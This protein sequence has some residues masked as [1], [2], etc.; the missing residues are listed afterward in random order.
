MVSLWLL[1]VTPPV[2]DSVLLK[3]F[4]FAMNADSGMA[5]VSEF[6]HK[7][8]RENLHEC[9]LTLSQLHGSVASL[10]EDKRLSR[11]R[12]HVGYCNY[13]EPGRGSRYHR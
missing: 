9:R 3:L 7:H 13:S 1:V 11:C 5:V 10:D 6:F 2:E 8:L 12:E 4:H